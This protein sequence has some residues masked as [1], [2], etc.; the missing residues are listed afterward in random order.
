VILA[1]RTGVAPD[2]WLDDPRALATAVALLREIDRKR[3]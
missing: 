2:A 3:R 1:L